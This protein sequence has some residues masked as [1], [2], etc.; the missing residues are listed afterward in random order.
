MLAV[1]LQIGFR[2]VAG[3]VDEVVAADELLER[4]IALGEYLGAR[5]RDAIEAIK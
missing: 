3:L 1:Q 2:D 4:A 5:P